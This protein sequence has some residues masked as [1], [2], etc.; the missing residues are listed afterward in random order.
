ME[1]SPMRYL[2]HNLSIHFFLTHLPFNSISTKFSPRL[3]SNH[4]CEFLVGPAQNQDE[5]TKK[6]RRKEPIHQE[7]RQIYT[8]VT[9]NPSKDSKSKWLENS[10]KIP[11]SDSRRR[12]KQYMLN[13]QFLGKNRRPVLQTGNMRI[14]YGAN[15][16]L[17]H[18]IQIK[19]RKMIKKDVQIIYITCIVMTLYSLHIL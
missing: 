13:E 10:F 14:F 7:K 5:E 8:K 1:T 6:S 4:A 2:R 12:K 11:L 17:L 9:S 18:N 19:N 15:G 3:V 16:Q